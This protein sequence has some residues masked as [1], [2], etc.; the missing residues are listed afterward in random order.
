MT[1]AEKLDYIGG[2]EMTIRAVP[3]AGVRALQMSDGP[4]GVRLDSGFPSTTYAGGIALAA[5]WDRELAHH[6]GAGIGRDARARGINFMLG[7]AVNIYRSPRNGR[8]F[9]YFGEDPFLTSNIAVGYI[10]GM[11]EQGVSSTIKHYLGNNSEFLRHDSDSIIDARTMHEIYLPAFEAAVKKAHVGAVMDSYNL[12]NGTH[13][14]Q[15]IP[16][17]LDIMRK[18]FGFEGTIMSDWDATYDGVAAANGGL[19]LEMPHGTYMNRKNL[20]PAIQS[21]KV[22]E[23]TI[24]EKVRH[25]LSTAMMFGWLDR[26]QTD[27]SISYVDRSN[28]QTA[29][30]S[31]RESAVLLK[32]DGDVLPLDRTRIKSILIVGPDAYPGVPV[33]GGSAGVRPFHTISP[34]EGLTAAL[35]RT[36]TVF[37]DRGVPRISELAKATEFTTEPMNGKPGLTLE[38]F[39]NHDLNGQPAS[40]TV[41]KNINTTGIS[42]DLM[43]SDPEMVATLFPPGRKVSRR[44]TGYYTAA[45]AGRYILAVE[46]SGE[47]SNNRVFVDGRQVIDDWELVR[48]FAPHVTLSLTAGPHK[49]VVEERQDFAVGGK[50]RVA[51]VPEEKI[52]SERAKE[53]AAKTDVVVVAAGFDQ[54]SESEGGDR[55]FDLPYGQDELIRE[56]AA[57]NKKV[58]VAVTSGGNVDSSSWLNRVPALLETWYGGQDGG[59]ALAEILLGEVNPSGHL[60]A[61]FERRAED[62]PTF[63]NYYPEP[64]TKRVVYKEG[65]FVGYRGYEHNQVKALFPF[66]YGLSYT[67]FKFANLAVSPESAG[68]N[69]Q[70]MVTFDVTNTGSR[71]GAEVAQVYVSPDQAKV[72][73]PERELK[74]FERVSLEPGETKHVSVTLDARA[75]AYWSADS[76]KWTIDPGKFTVHVGDSVE[77]TPLSGGVELT[78]AAANSTF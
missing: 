9:E 20:E 66:G 39:H 78:S 74:G 14:T 16:L 25:I 57:A 45:S 10:N 44:Y 42:W 49:V 29:L 27:A 35:V 72:E 46:A 51:I 75:F 68:A 73:R 28:R 40:T 11:Q 23:A 34:L 19:D 5:S 1:L 7:P 59:R 58:I 61:T 12:I 70:V 31:A 18:E 71:K 33:G 24:D 3:S 8:N 21:G 37:Y 76:K 77:D 4:I 69:P 38:T 50:L 64:G 48:A 22:S 63:A 65:I 17:N 60:P 55:T 52:V 2:M 67:T 43:D 62:N 53:L 41:A 32:N 30:D 36:A 13:A 47:G 15:N 54:D 56:M 6:V 26:D